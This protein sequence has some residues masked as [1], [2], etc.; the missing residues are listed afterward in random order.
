M[1]T[2]QEK[3]FQIIGHVAMALLSVMAIVPV[4]LLFMSSITDD[5]TLIK[6]GYNFFPEKFSLYAFE[7]VF[8]S[9]GKV[10]RAYGLSVVLTAVGV[11][12][13]LFVTT[14]LAYALSKKDVVGVKFLTFI[15]FFTMLFNGGLVPTYINYTNVFHIKDTF[16]ALLLPSLVTNGMYI[17][18]MKSYFVA[19][20]P[21]E[22]MEAAEI[23]GAG[24]FK[25]FTLIS[26]PLAKPIITTIGLFSGIGYW[27]DWNNGFIYIM[28]RTDLYSIQNLLNRM[29]QNIQFLTQGAN[30]VANADSGLAQIPSVSIRMSMA[31]LGILPIIL[32]Y[33]FVQKNFVKG[34]TLGGVKG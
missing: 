15:V 12:L 34:I 5:A 9:G 1:F 3:V 33:P 18:L 8:K 11:T 28:K 30:T 26:I 7:Y 32:V 10:L 2:K 27:N 13:S 20:I 16:W 6:N 24:P 4:V 25:V 29:I 14:T 22:I 19:S 31:V 21:D 23:D 17:M